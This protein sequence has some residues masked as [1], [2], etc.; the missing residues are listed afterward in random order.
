MRG[1]PIGE[2]HFVLEC[3]GGKERKEENDMMARET[4]GNDDEPREKENEISF[5]LVLWVTG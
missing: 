1:Y 2:Q 3:R 4:S 5:F